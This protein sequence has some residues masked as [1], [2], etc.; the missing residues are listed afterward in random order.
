MAV[1]LN[2]YINFNGNAAEAV[3]F[4][5][6]VFGGTVDMDTFRSFTERTPDSGMPVDPA[7]MDKVMHAYIKGDHGIELMISDVAAGMQPV[8]AGSQVTLTLNGDDVAILKGYWDKLSEGGTITMPLNKA[9]WGDEFG[10]VTD[11]FGI[12]WMFDIGPEVQQG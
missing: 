8:T 3:D 10:L 4:Y 1:R 12:S 9:P 11:K 6:S 2:S 5:A 7:D